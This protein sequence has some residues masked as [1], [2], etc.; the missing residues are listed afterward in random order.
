MSHAKREVAAACALLLV[1]RKSRDNRPVGRS[2]SRVSVKEHI[3]ITRRR[4]RAS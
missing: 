1:H 4:G 3:S 2:V